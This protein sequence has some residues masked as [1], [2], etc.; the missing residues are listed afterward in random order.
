MDL[1]RLVLWL[2]FYLS[3]TLWALLAV[4]QRCYY[5]SALNCRRW[6]LHSARSSKDNGPGGKRGGVALR[7]AQEP[8]VGC[9]R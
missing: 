1:I 8:L 3:V 2:L 4:T 6:D 5:C 7:P 9:Y